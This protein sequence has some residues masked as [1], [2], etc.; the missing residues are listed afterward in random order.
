MSWYKCKEQ[1]VRLISKWLSQPGTGSGDEGRFVN[2]TVDHLSMFWNWESSYRFGHQQRTCAQSRGRD[3]HRFEWGC[4]KLFPWS[5]KT[6]Q[7]L[8]QSG[9]FTN[10]SQSQNS[11]LSVSDRSKCDSTQERNLLSLAPSVQ[12]RNRKDFS[13]WNYHTNTEASSISSALQEEPTRRAGVL[14]NPAHTLSYHENT[15]TWG[16]QH[17]KGATTS[18]NKRRSSENNS[19]VS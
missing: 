17:S 7:I 4:W 6:Q 15:E 11:K 1:S 2:F 5:T 18:K 14:E 8:L 16:L 9:G 13:V 12:G 10:I 3:Q 19:H